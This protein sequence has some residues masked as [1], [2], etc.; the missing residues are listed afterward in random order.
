MQTKRVMIDI[1]YTL[2]EEGQLQHSHT[3]AQRVAPDPQRPYCGRFDR[4]QE[5]E[6]LKTI[7]R[8]I[9][10]PERGEPTE[11]SIIFEL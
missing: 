9:D 1:Q 7:Q 6:E 5:P 2:N 8:Y 11:L 3:I 4:D 10:E